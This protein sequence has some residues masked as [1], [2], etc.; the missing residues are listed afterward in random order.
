MNCAVKIEKN[1]TKEI[2]KDISFYLR[3]GMMTLLLG[4]PGGG[5]STLLKVFIKYILFVVLFYCRQLQVLANCSD[6]GT[7]VG[8]QVLFNNHQIDKKT[9]HRDVSYIMHV[10]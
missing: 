9:H 10:L 2:L 8:G 5:R 6:P 4:N 7:V 1:G 3:P